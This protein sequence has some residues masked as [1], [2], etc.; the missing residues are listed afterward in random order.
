[1]RPILRKGDEGKEVQGL[2]ELLWENGFVGADNP[3]WYSSV[4]KKYKIT[5]PEDDKAKRFWVDGDFGSWTLAAVIDAQQRLI[6]PHKVPLDEVTQPGVVDLDTWWALEHITPDEQNQ[7]IVEDASNVVTDG[8]G[9]A[10]SNVWDHY[11]GLK[12]H[13]IPNGSNRVPY[14]NPYWSGMDHGGIDA[15]TGYNPAKKAKGPA[16]CCYSRCRIE[17]EANGVVYGKGGYIHAEKRVGLCYSN[18]KWGKAQDSKQLEPF[19]SP[20]YLKGWVVDKKHVISGDVKLP[21]GTCAIMNYGG[22][23]GHTF[24]VVGFIHNSKGRLVYVITREGNISNSVGARKRRLDQSS[25]KWF[26][27]SPLLFAKP[28]FV[29]LQE[30]KAQFS[31]DSE[32][33][34]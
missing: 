24:T 4:A 11:I 7:G 15:W 1:M 13:E 2:Q 3:F 22:I 18:M 25:L 6:G 23:S 28:D 16:W 19:I 21:V 12:V 34:R 26:V 5:S 30:T 33:T 10:I 8:L 17:W 14:V 32:H 27:V 29:G 9:H 31:G 20:K